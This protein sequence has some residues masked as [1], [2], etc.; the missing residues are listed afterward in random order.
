MRRVGGVL[1]GVLLLAALLSAQD[2]RS[3][4]TGQ[5]KD[6]QGALIAGANVVVTNT[7]TR[8]SVKLST[9]GSGYFEAPLLQPGP[10]EVT[11]ESAGFKKLVRRGITLQAADRRSVDLLLEVGAVTES[12]DVTAEPPLID[13]GRT[14]SGRTLD[15]QSVAALPVMGNTVMT[16]I[17]Y[18]PGVAAGTPTTLIGPHSTQSAG[19]DATTGTGIG[20]THGRSTAR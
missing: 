17:R 3:T 8:V 15:A 12:V 13:V 6:A 2:A 4:L 16:M 11:A 1:A 14:D 20:A 7:E 9:N 10:Y 18:A 5:V 19:Y